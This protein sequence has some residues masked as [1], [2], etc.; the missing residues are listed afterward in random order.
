MVRAVVHGGLGKA[1]AAR[2]YNTT[3]K[4]VGN[5]SSASALKV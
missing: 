3:R 4:T 1:I 5:G 2:K